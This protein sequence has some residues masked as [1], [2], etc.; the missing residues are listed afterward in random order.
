[1]KAYVFLATGYEEIEALTS[2]D[3]LRRGGFEVITVSMQN[4]KE[5]VGS[6]GIKVIADSTFAECDLRDA[7]ALILPGGMPG[8]KAL[9]SNEELAKALKNQFEAGRLVAA[10]C[11]APSVLGHIGLLKGKKATC[12]PGFE[13]EL[14]GAEFVDVL[15]VGDGNIVTGKSIGGAMDF[16]LTIYEKLCGK[17]S[18]KNLEK[19][20]CR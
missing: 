14:E 12:Y 20:L 17:E 3:V 19:T 15:A 6:H 11:A 16:A 4:E 18:R 2:V 7:D 10:I 13:Q 5:A 1:M 9:D 8:T